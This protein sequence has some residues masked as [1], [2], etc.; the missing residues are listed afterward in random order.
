LRLDA[1]RGAV[2]EIPQ[3]PD[4]SLDLIDA[5]ARRRLLAQ[6]NLLRTQRHPNPLPAAEA[7]ELIDDQVAAG[8]GAAYHHVAGLGVVH[9][10]FEQVGRT[11]EIGD[12]SIL[13]EL[14]DFRR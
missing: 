13:R 9:G 6:A 7:P 5:V 10:A 14:V 11:D 12:K 2:A 1:I 3:L 4:D 8:L